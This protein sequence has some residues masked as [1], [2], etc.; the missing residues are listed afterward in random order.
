MTTATIEL[1]AAEIEARVDELL[2]DLDFWKGGFAA[3]ADRIDAL[4]TRVLIA[5]VAKMAKETPELLAAIQ[6]TRA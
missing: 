2:G 1:T 5:L 3:V 6:A 4:P